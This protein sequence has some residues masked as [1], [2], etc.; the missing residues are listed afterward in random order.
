MGGRLDKTAAA[1]YRKDRKGRCDKRSALA[2][3]LE[4][5]EDPKKP[6]PAGVAVS[7]FYDDGHRKISDVESDPHSLHPLSGGVA[8]RLPLCSALPLAGQ[9]YHSNFC[10]VLSML[11][12]S[13]E[14]SRVRSPFVRTG[15]IPL[16][17]RPLRGLLNHSQGNTPP[18]RGLCG[19][20][21]PFFAAA[22]PLL[23]AAWYTGLVKL[24][25]AA[26]ARTAGREGAYPWRSCTPLDGF[27][28]FSGI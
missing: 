19:L 1:W 4:T 27:F 14:V 8:N 2:W 6:S 7:A 16:R 11:G 5:Q 9:L 23:A 26:R 22:L 15:D 20:A 25:A 24:R 28:T 21:T 12:F 10:R 3:K 13:P 17:K 18:P